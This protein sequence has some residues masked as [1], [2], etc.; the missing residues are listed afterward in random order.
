MPI[1]SGWANESGTE[2]FTIGWVQ[3]LLAAI[4][5]ACLPIVGTSWLA[6][7]PE[8][9]YTHGWI[10]CTPPIVPPILPTLDGGTGRSRR[11]VPGIT[12]NRSMAMREDEEILAMLEAYFNTKRH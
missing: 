12:G 4:T 6:N 11:Q 7:C 3:E 10:C 2:L 5:A 9:H 8:Q 1:Q